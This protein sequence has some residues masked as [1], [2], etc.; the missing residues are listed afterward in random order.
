M[1]F[2]T[3]FHGDP[4]FIYGIQWLPL[5]TSLY[6]LGRDPAFNRYQLEEMLKGQAAKKNGFTFSDLKADWGNVTLG[7]SQFGDPAK[8][9]EQMDQLWESKD[10]I[11]HSK[12]IAGISYYFAHA[13]RSLGPVA[14][15][16]HT[17]LPSSLVFRKN[18]SNLATVVAYHAGPQAV[19]CRVYQKDKVVG[20][21]QVP[22]G[23]LTVHDLTLSP[24]P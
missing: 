14:W 23:Q 9:V 24:Q 22:S 5:T 11:A 6:Y 15:D 12:N 7:Y 17:N 3:F 2:G 20:E 10:E 21:F 16:M 1:A 13:N 4:M 18:P 8:T 19:S